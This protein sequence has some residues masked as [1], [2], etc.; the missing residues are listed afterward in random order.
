MVQ[1]AAW[2]GLVVAI[3]PTLGPRVLTV[4]A[5]AFL[6]VFAALVLANGKSIRWSSIRNVGIHVPH[7][8]V[9]FVVGA[10]EGIPNVLIG[11]GR[12]IFD[13]LVQSHFQ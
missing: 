11:D 7:H 13:D 2:N 8:S 10:P 6:L 5:V 1:V 3:E 4:V 12:M 9:A